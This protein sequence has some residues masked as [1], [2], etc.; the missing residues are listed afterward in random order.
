[1]TSL[2]ASSGMLSE[3]RNPKKKM[4]IKPFKLQPK[5]PENFEEKTWRNLKEAIV[6]VQSNQGIS[7]SR[8]ELYR[9]VEDM[10]TWKMSDR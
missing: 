5:L 7:F 4:I 9:S 3:G 2:E 6:A 8:E 10:C 1:M